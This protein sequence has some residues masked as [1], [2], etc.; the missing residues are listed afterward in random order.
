MLSV[1]DLYASIN[2]AGISV[3]VSSIHTVEI[4]T[5][6]FVPA[7]PDFPQ[8]RGTLTLTVPS[9]P[10]NTDGVPSSFFDQSSG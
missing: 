2:I 4:L 10:S 1:V 6:L 3:Q 9:V 7:T 8:N 5:H